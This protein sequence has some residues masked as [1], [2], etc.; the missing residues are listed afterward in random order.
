[1]AELPRSVRFDVITD[2]TET[3]CKDACK[4]LALVQVGGRGR[5][6][7]TAGSCPQGCGFRKLMKN[8]KPSGASI[9]NQVRGVP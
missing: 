1:V 2:I 7:D 9:S 3:V 5:G 6:R 8:T 4:M